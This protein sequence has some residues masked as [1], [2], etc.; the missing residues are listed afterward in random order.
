VT[1]SIV[2]RDPVSGELGVAVQSHW[3]SVGSVVSWAEAGVGAVAT[4]SLVDPA[5]GPR[6]LELMRKGKSAPDALA[7]LV[8]ADRDEAVR[9]VAMVD[10]GGRTAVHTGRRCVREAGHRL[11]PQVSVQANM[12][13]RGTVWDAMMR[14]YQSAEG[15]L[16]ERLLTALEAAEAEGGDIRG[17]QS[18]ALLVVSAR[19][20]GRAWEDRLVDLRVDDSTDPIGELGRLLRLKRAYDRMERGD[21]LLGA[22]DTD[23]ALAEY[24]AAHGAVRNNPEPGFWHG[25]TLAATGRLEEGR[26]LVDEAMRADPGWGELLRRLPAA[27]LMD[28]EV[29]DQLLAGRGGG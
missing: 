22:G 13:L 21:D 5:Y 9:Q 11:G 2:A 23:G 26:R 28:R 27:G 20:S 4:Q 15:P 6:G 7:A 19:A 10:R 18:A 12:M 16:A 17:S 14:A 29:A 25:A 8:A 24:S 3:F 1:Y